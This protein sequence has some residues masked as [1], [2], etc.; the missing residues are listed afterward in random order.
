MNVLVISAHP[1][2]EILG[3]GSTIAKH[4]Q[5][6]DTVNVLL[7]SKG[8]LSRDGTDI[9]LIQKVHLSTVKAS[10]LLGYKVNW[11]NFP[12]Q[13]F[14]TVGI[15]N[16]S[17]AIERE[18]DRVNPDIMYTHSNSDRNLDHRIAYDASMVATRI[19]IK[20][21]YCY[22]VPSSTEWGD[23]PFHANYFVD[24]TDT[25]DL[26]LQALSCYNSEMREPPHPRSNQYIEGLARVRG[27]QIG[28]EYAESFCQVRR[29]G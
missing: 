16:I 29:L 1:D 2:D 7:L 21:I 28:V 6:G 15:L 19:S 11:E 14:D 26:K 25:F 22:E 5:S 12:D 27:G 9:S 24:V 10:K 23:R 8:G 18:I 20:N 17:K 3:P 13:G 4:V